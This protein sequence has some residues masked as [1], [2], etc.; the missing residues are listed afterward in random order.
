MD[1]NLSL[2][3]TMVPIGWDHVSFFLSILLLG[4]KYVIT[5]EVDSLEPKDRNREFRE[6]KSTGDIMREELRKTAPHNC[7]ELLGSPQT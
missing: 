4:L 1:G 5:I 7:F 2:S 3:G 6:P